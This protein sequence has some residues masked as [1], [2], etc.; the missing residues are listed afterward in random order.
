MIEV[1]GPYKKENAA[2]KK[3]I[4]AR[5]TLKA[6]S[7]EA[8]DKAVELGWE[9][10]I[11]EERGRVREIINALKQSLTD[12]EEKAKKTLDIVLTLVLDYENDTKENDV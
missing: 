1:T 12:D 6:A 7:D 5:D 9:L 3:S 2:T 4:E 11:I 10:G 8:F